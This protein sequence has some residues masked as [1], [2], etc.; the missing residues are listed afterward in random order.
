MKKRYC[1]PDMIRGLAV[2][3]M[4]AYHT[5]WDL[6]YIYNV[7]IPFFDGMPAYLW[8]Q[9]I[10][11]CFILLS[12][13][14]FGF[15]GKSYKRGI[16]VFLAGVLVSAVTL[17]VMPQNRIIF[18]VL[19]FLGTAMIIAKA[20]YPVAVKVKHAIGFALSVALFLL[21]KSFCKGFVGIG[22]WGIAR[23][24][25]WLYRGGYVSALF[26]F[27][28]SDFYSSDYF[29]VFPW[30]FLFFAGFYIFILLRN[31]KVMALWEK[32]RCKALEFVGRYS[33]I[34]YLAHQPLIYLILI[35]AFGGTK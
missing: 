21:T 2:V 19:T 20:V 7:D 5:L 6:F 25:D 35:T 13:F 3:N 14:S 17:I 22:D 31:T 26:G 11:T 16:R 34:I 18:G 10:C 12:G 24:P 29:P 33:L 1:L 9:S 23:L 32:S 28:P 4:I 8:Q 27:P 15:G 30:L